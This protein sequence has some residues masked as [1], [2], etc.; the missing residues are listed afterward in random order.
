MDAIEFIGKYESYIDEISL[1]IKPTLQP[2]LNELRKIDPHDLISP[3]SWFHSELEARGFVWKMFI[4]RI[5]R[6]V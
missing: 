5:K 2:V 6:M 3:D 4:I 1:I